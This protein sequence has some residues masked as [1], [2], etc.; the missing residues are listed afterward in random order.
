MNPDA[1][2]AEKRRKRKSIECISISLVPGHAVGVS[3]NFHY[4]G[5]VRLTEF[6]E[7]AGYREQT[8]VW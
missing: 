5:F 6:F 2:E 8:I 4:F 7:A 1:K 3:E